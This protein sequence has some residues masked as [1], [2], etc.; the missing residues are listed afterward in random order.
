M[1]ETNSMKPA[2]SLFSTPLSASRPCVGTTIVGSRVAP[3]TSRIWCSTSYR[4]TRTATSYCRHGKVH[5]SS[6]RSSSLAPTSLRPSTA[7]SSPTLG[8][9]SSY[10]TFTL[11]FSKLLAYLHKIMFLKSMKISLVGFATSPSFLSG[12]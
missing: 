8:I 4:A 6:W 7:K 12:A 5:T 11:S 10:V 9:L 2:T 1:P 3:S